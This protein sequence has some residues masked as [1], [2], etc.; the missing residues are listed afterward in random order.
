MGIQQLGLGHILGQRCRWWTRLEHHSLR[1][2]SGIPTRLHAHALARGIAK[3][4]ARFR[5]HRLPLLAKSTSKGGLA[6]NLA[7]HK[8]KGVLPK[9]VGSTP[10]HQT[11]RRDDFSF[12][13]PTEAPHDAALQ[14]KAVL[15][16]AAEMRIEIIDLNQ[17]ERN[18]PGQCDIRTAT[19]GPCKCVS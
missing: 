12:A 14:P 2:R 11:G 16:S 13:L 18:M 4:A 17:S 3:S 9:R 6:F 5:R 1:C 7:N 15:R 19:R 10:L 8:T